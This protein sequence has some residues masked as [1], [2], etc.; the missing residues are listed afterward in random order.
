MLK[1][2]SVCITSIGRANKQ[3]VHFVAMADAARLFC[4]G[5]E[6]NDEDAES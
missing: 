6:K 3:R 1:A 4:D 5:K 2:A